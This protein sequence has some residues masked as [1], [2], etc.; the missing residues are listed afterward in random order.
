M[1][2]LIDKMNKFFWGVMVKYTLIV[3]FFVIG[4]IIGDHIYEKYL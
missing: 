2:D 3:M 1:D 4:W